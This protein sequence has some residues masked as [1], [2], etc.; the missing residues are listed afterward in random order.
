MKL[1]LLGPVD[2]VR[3]WAARL[4]R[5]GFVGREYPARENGWLRWYG[6]IDDRRA[7]EDDLRQL[8]LPL[9][10]RQR[11]AVKKAAKKT[12]QVRLRSGRK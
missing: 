4:S 8:V 6:D 1:R 11:T 7:V 12:A 5:M 9:H 2:V 3:V 10:T